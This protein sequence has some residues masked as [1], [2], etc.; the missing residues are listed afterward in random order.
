MATTNE[1]Q[2]SMPENG[3]KSSD[4]QAELK[5]PE[6][7]VFIQSFNPMTGKAEWKMFPDDYD[8][9]QEVA[10]AAF[11]DMLHDSERVS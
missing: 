2:V 9:Q 6:S 8:Y 4:L 5:N 10:R 1:V 7:G 11:A 3:F